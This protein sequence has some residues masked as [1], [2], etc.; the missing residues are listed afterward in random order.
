MPGSGAR[1][2]GVSKKDESKKKKKKKNNNKKN[3]RLSLTQPRYGRTL[4]VR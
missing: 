1:S 2:S 4:P 3:R